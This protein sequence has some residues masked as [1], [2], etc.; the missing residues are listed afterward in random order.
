MKRV[1]ACL[2][3]L[4]L[5]L[6]T[7]GL[8][9]QVA[10]PDGAV[11]TAPDV[12]RSEE[13]AQ[14]SAAGGST[15]LDGVI[16]TVFDGAAQVAGYTA[17]IPQNCVIP[18]S[19]PM[20]G[21]DYPVTALA[22]NALYNCAKLTSITL[23]ETVTS[24]GTKSLSGCTGLTEIAIPAAVTAIATDAL[25]SCT[26][27]ASITVAA[28]NAGGYYG[29]GRCLI[30]QQGYLLQYAL[31]SGASYAIP[32]GTTVIT[33]NAFRDSTTLESVTLPDSVTTIQGSA[34]YGCKN[35]SQVTFGQG[36]T[37]IDG[38]AFE[39]CG[40]IRVDL[41]AGLSK[42][43]AYVFADCP[44]EEFTVAGDG[45]GN[46]YAVDGVLFAQ[47]YQGEWRE[48]NGLRT[49]A[50]YPAGSTR[51]SYAVPDGVQCVGE[52]AFWCAENLT[53]VT[54]PNSLT[55]IAAGAFTDTGITSVT[56]PDT[57]TYLGP[58]VFQTNKK[59]V[60]AVF[61][62]GVTQLPK[63]TFYR[64]AALE[65][66]TL[67]ETIAEIDAESFDNCFALKAI[68]VAEDNPT[69][70]D[71]DGAL[72]SKDGARLLLCP[73]G[74][75]EVTVPAEVTTIDPG[76]F[77]ACAKVS[78]FTVEPGNSVFYAQDG[79]LFQNEE[80]GTVAL[81]SY[82]VGKTDAV[83]TV[84]AGVT[85][86]GERAFNGNSALTKLDTADVTEIS[87]WAVY[88][89]PALKEVVLPKVEKLGYCCLWGIAGPAVEF[90]STLWEMGQQV[91]DYNDY[92]EYV[93]FGGNTPSFDYRFMGDGDKLRYVYVPAWTLLD[94][95]DA[96]ARAN[97]K[98]GV[99]IVEGQ[100]VPK[101]TVEE[102]IAALDEDSPLAEVNTA[103][104]GVVRMLTAEKKALATDLL[105]KIDR[106][107]QTIHAGLDVTVDQA[108]VTDTDLTVQGLAVASGLVERQDETGAVSG[109]VKLTATQETPQAEDELL[110]LDFALWV[111]NAAAQ[112]QSPVVVTLD[113]PQALRQGIFHLIHRDGKTE[114]QVPFE[115][116]GDKVTFRA[117][118]FSSYV[119]RAGEAKP[120]VSY[121]ASAAATLFVAG[122]RGGQMVSVQGFPVAAGTGAVELEDYD[123]ALTYK[124]FILGGNQAPVGTAQVMVP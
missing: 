86:I 91:I 49:L 75:E 110:V 18:A 74:V 114:S 94:Y 38:W 117:D 107:F 93:S 123:S 113:L 81:H 20:D 63:G 17:D 29:D 5:V 76:A 42:L 37:D 92:L 65:E 108:K 4:A 8:A 1:F 59:L 64:C 69:Y 36:L 100:Y 23:P 78:A 50:V 84:P 19:V 103:A 71:I 26:G 90:P 57:V 106:L 79:V 102:E 34:F 27:L 47:S 31:N 115:R 122:Y 30:D 12:A 13:L 15:T 70:Q 53:E 95:K 14:L 88:E 33:Y 24:L 67:S 3:L 45:A 66:V 35:L 56:V 68:H 43:G 99:M 82:P 73:A 2:T 41:P 55:H 83:Y 112:P 96:L 58:D 21:E 98:P 39:Y 72:Y 10:G 89:T 6:A 52:A 77:V 105:V 101:A 11:R 121:Q 46:F 111:D 22:D 120:R 40:L 9:A 7:P 119:F 60:Q 118:S 124:A 48:C 116:V 80:G 54:F 104:A 61:G 28:D 97:L 16:Y 87:R 44:V 25:Q 62:S 51:T 32:E 109:S 85:R